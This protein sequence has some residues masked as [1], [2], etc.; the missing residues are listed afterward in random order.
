VQHSR[1]ACR[2]IIWEIWALSV[3]DRE[4]DSVVVDEGETDELASEVRIGLSA[5]GGSL[6]RTRLWSPIPW[7]LGKNTGNL[8]RIATGT[9]LILRDIKDLPIEFPSS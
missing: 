8:S 4:V 2:S 5:G 7:L 6:Q 9:L 1:A 3:D